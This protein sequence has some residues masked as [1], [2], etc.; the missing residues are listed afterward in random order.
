MAEK[1]LH[2]LST[3]NEFR[4]AFK[5]DP[6]AALMKL[7]HTDPAMAECA[8]IKAIAPKKEFVASGEAFKAHAM[9]AGMFTNPH[10]CEAGQVA[11]R[12]RRK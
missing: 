9:S 8:S 12:L 1:L 7:G 3:D 4:R 6:A 11:T 10:C 5:K 2:L